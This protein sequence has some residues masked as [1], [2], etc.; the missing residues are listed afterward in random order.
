M[1][2]RK[3]DLKR[4]NLR[5]VGHWKLGINTNYNMIFPPKKYWRTERTEGRER[6]TLEVRDKRRIVWLQCLLVF[7]ASITK[8]LVIMNCM[9]ARPHKKLYGPLHFKRSVSYTGLLSNGLAGELSKKLLFKDI[10]K[11]LGFV[12]VWNK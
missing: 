12:S 6:W 8:K 7:P 5:V 2:V 11:E 1:Y 9:L 4:Y 10:I 3:E